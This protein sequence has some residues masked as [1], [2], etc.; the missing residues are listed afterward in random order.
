MFSKEKRAGVERENQPT[1]TAI[2]GLLGMLDGAGAI[3][4]RFAQTLVL[5][6]ERRPAQFRGSGSETSRWIPSQIRQRI[7]GARTGYSVRYECAYACMM[8]LPSRSSRR[9]DFYE[10]VAP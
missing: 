10:E 5:R 8:E 7:R 1:L 6:W 9:H 4:G 3:V 2:L